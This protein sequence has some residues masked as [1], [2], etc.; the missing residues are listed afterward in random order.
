MNRVLTLISLLTLACNCHAAE[1]RELL[2]H[3]PASS[4]LANPNSVEGSTFDDA[5]E[6][7]L[8]QHLQAAALSLDTST[9]APAPVDFRA[10]ARELL[11]KVSIGSWRMENGA[12]VRLTGDRLRLSYG[13]KYRVNLVV[14]P[15]KDEDTVS[16]TVH[17]SF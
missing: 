16:L 15:F 13:E 4:A 2:L 6:A 5:P 10:N 3:V 12:V 11:N 17:H 1:R 9:P 14:R 8:Q 7:R